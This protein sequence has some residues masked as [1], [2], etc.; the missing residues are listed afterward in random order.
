MSE[1]KVVIQRVDINAHGA[2]ATVM[3]YGD[4][5][6][7]VQVEMEV[8]SSDPEVSVSELTRIAA[9]KFANQFAELAQRFEELTV[10]PEDHL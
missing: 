5:G 7:L 2:T 10:K 6:S 8:R 9:R 1:A 4:I 3:G